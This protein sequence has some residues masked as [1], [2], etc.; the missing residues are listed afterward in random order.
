VGSLTLELP[1]NAGQPWV[2]SPQP[3]GGLAYT[4]PASWQ[5]LISQQAWPG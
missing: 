5:W 1:R 4:V 3:Q 2:C